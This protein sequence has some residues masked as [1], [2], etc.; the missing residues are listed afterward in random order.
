MEGPT[1]H[2]PF[3]LCGIGHLDRAQ[4]WLPRVAQGQLWMYS[5]RAINESHSCEEG[6]IRGG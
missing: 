1:W 2:L 5:K 6:E 3:P 4:G